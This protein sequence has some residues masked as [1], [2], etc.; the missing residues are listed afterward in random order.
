METVQ[1]IIA[2]FLFLIGI[3]IGSFL[4]V[5][6]YRLPLGMSIVS[7]PSACRYCGHPVRWRDNIPIVS[8]LL[9]G[10]K[11]RS[12]GGRLSREYPIVELLGGMIL[13]INYFLFQEIGAGFIYFSVMTY[14]L[15]VIAFLDYK[16]YWI[17]NKLILAGV[18]FGFAGIFAAPELSF[19][20]ALIGAFSG[21]G[22]L[23]AVRLLGFLLFR[24][25]SLGWGDVKL[26]FMTGVFLGMEKTLLAIFLGFFLPFF[27]ERAS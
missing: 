18:V 4:N 15:L 9:L 1:S 21:G 16:F 13:V 2:V 12:C 7:P 10:G 23:L 17:P 19:R 6:I 14:L 8:F 22:S 25:E 26:G 11:C 5:C 3:S 24:K 27:S 20:T